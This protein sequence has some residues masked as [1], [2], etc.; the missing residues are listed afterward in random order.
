MNQPGKKSPRNSELIR[1]IVFTVAIIILYRLLVLIP[2]PLVN[3]EALEELFLEYNQPAPISTISILALGLIPYISAYMLVEIGSLFIPFLKRLRGGDYSGRHKLKTYALLLTII[4]GALHGYGLVNGFVEIASPTGLRVISVQGPIDYIIPIV[5]MLGGVFLLI[6][7]AELIS[8]YGVGH[9]I[10]VII[11]TGML[12]KFGQDILRLHKLTNIDFNM[13]TSPGTFVLLIILAPIFLILSAVIFLKAKKPV[14]VS[15]SSLLKPVDYFQ[16]NLCP[17]GVAALSWSFTV[18]MLLFFFYENFF[19]IFI[20]G[21]FFYTVTMLILCTGFS[22]FFAWGFLHPKRRVEKL[23][24]RSWTLHNETP[25][26]L[27]RKVMIYNLPWSF[28]LY[29][30]IV[31]ANFNVPVVHLGDTGLFVGFAIMLDILDRI[32][33]SR[34]STAGR[35]VKISEIHDVYD[36]AMIKNHIESEGI[37]C[38]LQGYYHRCLLYFFGP[39]IEISVMVPDNERERSKVLI[40]DFYE[41]MGLVG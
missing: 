22:Y 14:L 27:L 39:Y 41:S 31:Q 8:R 25:E 3:Q 20:I 29:L 18:L 16:L 26:T 34:R 12:G 24:R 5:T 6:L 40:R 23:L 28:F 2:L 38:H 35:F 4:I 21:S 10:S 11:L 1:S 33:L 32:N 13:G 7:L 37:P 30:F 9:G 36:A 17:S 19:S 15:H